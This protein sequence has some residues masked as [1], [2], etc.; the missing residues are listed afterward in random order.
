MKGYSS[1]KPKVH[2]AWSLISMVLAM[3]MIA[4]LGAW[5]AEWLAP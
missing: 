3:L 4:E 1:G 5:I 2:W